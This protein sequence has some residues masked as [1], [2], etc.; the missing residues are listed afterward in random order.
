MKQNRHEEKNH[1]NAL[2]LV[3]AEEMSENENDSDNDIDND[4]ND[5]NDSEEGTNSSSSDYTP[6][7]SSSI[8]STTRKNQ[9][10]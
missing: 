1:L 9:T 10:N 2:Q 5:K 8:T 6:I 7:N 4:N 3:V